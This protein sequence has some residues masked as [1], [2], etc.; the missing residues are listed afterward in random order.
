MV[1]L[2]CRVRGLGASGADD[3]EHI[4]GGADTFWNSI[5]SFTARFLVV[6]T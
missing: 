2:F 3:A 5:M 1:V 6:S 4:D